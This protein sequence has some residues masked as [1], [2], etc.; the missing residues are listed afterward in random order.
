MVVGSA[1]AAAGSAQTS[2]AQ[3]ET[4]AAKQKAAAANA[5]AAGKLPLGAVVTTLPAGCDSKT[6]CGVQ[7]YQCDGNYYRSAFQGNNLVYVTAQPE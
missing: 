2:Q 3:Q 7:Y 5:A 6:V 1:T 4:A